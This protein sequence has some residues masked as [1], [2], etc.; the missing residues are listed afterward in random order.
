LWARTRAHTGA[1]RHEWDDHF[2]AYRYICED[3]AE[4]IKADALKFDID[5]TGEEKLRG[6]GVE[7]LELPE[8]LM[9][10]VSTYG[11][12]RYAYLDEGDNCCPT[13]HQ[14]IDLRDAVE[15]EFEEAM[16]A[17]AREKKLAR[18]L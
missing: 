6:R 17:L 10:R 4:H 2:A 9:G 15:V 14:E 16:S 13:C 8:E 1:V 12:I 11:I 7:D 3:W 18:T 5:L